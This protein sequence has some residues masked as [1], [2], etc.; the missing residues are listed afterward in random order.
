MSSSTTPDLLIA[1]YKINLEYSYISESKFYGFS[2][3]FS[4]WPLVK[5]EEAKFYTHLAKMS[6]V[7]TTLNALNSTDGSAAA[8]FNSNEGGSQKTA[9]YTC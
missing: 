1:D 9:T 3:G 6:L 4:E 2:S 8:K 7:N 5:P